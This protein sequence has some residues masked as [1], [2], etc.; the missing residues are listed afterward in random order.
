MRDEPYYIVDD[1]PSMSTTTPSREDIDA[2]PVV[3]LEDMP[4]L[5]KGE[6]R[7]HMRCDPMQT[8]SRALFCSRPAPAG[9]PARAARTLAATRGRPRR[10]DARRGA[11]LC[12]STDVTA[13]HALHCRGSG[14]RA[15]VLIVPAVRRRRAAAAHTGTDRRDAGKEAGQTST[16]DTCVSGRGWRG[17]VAV[18]TGHRAP[19][20]DW[21]CADTDILYGRLYR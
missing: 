10:G 1:R 7:A 13:P 16:A 9:V 3:R 8:G 5:S 14:A 11:P 21:G 19:S 4:P 2:I 18:T 6:P 17:C 20:A 15:D 12:V